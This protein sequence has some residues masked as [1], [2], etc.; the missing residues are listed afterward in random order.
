MRLN[1]CPQHDNRALTSH[2][3]PWTIDHLQWSRNSLS[4]DL[5]FQEQKQNL[6][7]QHVS[8][9]YV[10]FVKISDWDYQA[11]NSTSTLPLN[12]SHVLCFVPHLFEFLMIDPDSWWIALFLSQLSVILGHRLCFSPVQE[13]P[14]HKLQ[15]DP[16]Q[17]GGVDRLYVPSEEIWLPDIVLYNKWVAWG[18]WF[19]LNPI[20]RSEVQSYCFVLNEWKRVLSRTLRAWLYSTCVCAGVFG[21]GTG[22]SVVFISRVAERDIRSDKKDSSPRL[23]FSLPPPTVR[24]RKQILAKHSLHAWM[25][26]W[27]R[28]CQN[29]NKDVSF[30][31]TQNCGGKGTWIT[32]P[33]AGAASRVQV[34]EDVRLR[35][36]P[37]DYGGVSDLHVPASSI[38]LPDVVLFNKY[39]GGDRV[40]VP[41]FWCLELQKYN[42]SF[43]QF[44]SNTKQI[45]WSFQSPQSLPPCTSLIPCERDR[46]LSLYVGCKYVSY[47]GAF[48]L[49]IYFWNQGP[50]FFEWNP[51]LPCAVRL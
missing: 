46:M 49:R 4:K 41:G 24:K 37:R 28:T 35:W 18:N 21:W 7:Y 17:Y 48:V 45:L 40:M 32:A 27:I 33:P 3:W 12:Y 42:P 43:L 38:W 20:C 14:D 36:D 11:Q 30:N 16:K 23:N 44:K 1:L 29:T 22:F 8:S 9:H 34:W 50:G 31:R 5:E 26:L 15:W 10:P 39:G 25:L 51:K 47:L 2:L 6:T 13:W 19:L